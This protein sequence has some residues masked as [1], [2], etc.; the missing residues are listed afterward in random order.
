MSFI[1]T[2]IWECDVP[3]P[4]GWDGKELASR[5]LGETCLNMFSGEAHKVTKY[6]QLML[7]DI[8]SITSVPKAERPFPDAPEG[9]LGAL[10]GCTKTETELKPS[11]LT[12]YI[13]LSDHSTDEHD[14]MAKFKD[15]KL[16]K[17]IMRAEYE[18][19]IADV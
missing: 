4:D 15:G 9:S 3:L 14:Y 12:G 17:I 11:D 16:V 1:D 10:F 19:L 6:G 18:R 8:L 5:T 13:D 2:V 7:V